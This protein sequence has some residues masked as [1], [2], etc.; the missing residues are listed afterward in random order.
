M[1]G[2]RCR[3]SVRPHTRSRNSTDQGRDPYK[4]RL[5]GTTIKGPTLRVSGVSSCVGHTVDVYRLHVSE[6][7]GGGGAG[8]G[9]TEGNG[10]RGGDGG[11]EGPGRDR[12]GSHNWTP[13]QEGG[14]IPVP[15][16]K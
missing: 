10:L 9:G 11:R 2:S 13:K 15:T 7:I 8:G 3:R 5:S 14:R 12:G 4:L 1:A 16:Q 6:G